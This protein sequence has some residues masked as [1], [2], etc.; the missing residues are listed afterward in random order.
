MPRNYKMHV[1]EVQ[2]AAQAILQF[3]AGRTI[4]DYRNDWVLRSAVERQINKIGGAAAKLAVNDNPI[5]RRV[6][7]SAGAVGNGNNDPMP[8]LKEDEI[9]S[10]IQNKLASLHAETTSVLEE[11]TEPKPLPTKHEQRTTIPLVSQRENEIRNLCRLHHVKRLDV[12]G[13]AVNG[14]FHTDESDIDFL[15]EFEDSQ[16]GQDFGTRFQLSK[17][18]EALFGRSVDLVDDA[19]IENP[20]FRQE[21]DQTRQPIY[22]S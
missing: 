1:W 12:F 5:A 16:E 13:S 22:A 21:V 19:A 10:F 8:G 20:Y 9:W 17:E 4:D 14:D 15:V 11:R 2:R 18:L 6:G 7:S 3:T